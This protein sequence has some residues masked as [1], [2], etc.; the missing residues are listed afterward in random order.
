[1]VPNRF[2]ERSRNS[3]IALVLTLV[4]LPSIAH[5]LPGDLD[6]SGRVDGY[7]LILFSHAHGTS[8]GDPDWNP[9]ADLDG[10]GTV[11]QTDLD[12]LSVHFGNTGLTFGLWVGDQWSGTDRVAKLSST[13]N[14]LT[15]V[16]NFY[17]PGS[18]SSNLVDGSVWVADSYYDQVTKLDNVDGTTL[19]TVAGMVPYS[20]SVN[21]SDGSVWVADFVNNRVIKLLSDITDGYTIG[22]DT[23]SHLVINGFNHPR[24]VSVNP[25]TGV[26]WIADTS[27]NRI[28]R[29]SPDV[30][31]GYDITVDI[32]KH[33][34]KDGFS[35]PYVVSVNVADG[36]VWVADYAN[37]QV[38]KLSATGTTELARMDGFN[39]PIALD[40]NPIDG[41]VWIA[42][43]LN[44][45]VTRLAAD[46]SL[47]FRVDG[48]Y[49]PS[50]VAVDPLDGSAWIADRYNHQVVKLSA[51]GTELLRVGGFS[52]PKALSLTL[53]EISDSKYPTAATS[54]SAN[55]VEVGE[56]IIFTGTGTDPD[57]SIVLYEWD[58][59]GDGI[60]EYSSTTSGTTT[61]A[62]YSAE[63]L[64][65][66][67]FRVTDNDWLTAT[68]YTQI[69][70][71]GVLQV[72][73]GA[74]VISGAAPLTV[75]FSG[76]FVDPL[77][78]FVD[79]Y[80][81]DFDGNHIFDYYSETS[82]ATSFTYDEAGT[83]TATLKVT[84]GPHTAFDS[85][86][87]AVTSSSPT[88]SASLSPTIGPYPL[89]VHFVGSGS[90]LDGTIVLYEWDFEGDGLYDWFSVSET[91]TA[92]IYTT[93]GAYTPQLRVTD[94]D[95]QTA[96]VDLSVEVGA[97]PPLAVAN[98]DVLE[99]HVP[100]TVNVNANGS[101]DPDGTIVLYEWNFGDDL[102]LFSDNMENGTSQWSAASPWAQIADDFH[103]AATAWTDSPGGNYTNNRNVSLTSTTIDLSGVSSAT[104]S[105]WHH[106][107]TEFSKDYGHVEISTD[108]GT[109]WTE[110]AAYSGT[111]SA[112][113]EVQ[114]DLSAYLP[115]SNVRIRFR[116]SSDESYVYDGWYLDDVML[117][118]DPVNWIESLD[119]TLS[120]SY[121]EAGTS[122]ATLRV[123]DNDGNSAIDTVEI[124]VIPSH[125]P[126]VTASAT[127]LSG[128][129]PLTVNF[130][131]TGID[132]DGSISEY[133]WNFGEEY[134]WVADYSNNQIV[135]LAADG[136]ELVRVSGFSFP[137]SVSV[138]PTDGSVWV[139][140]T[141]H[142]QVVKLTADGTELLRVSGFSSPR[143]V[144][145]NPT[146][147]S[148]WVANTSQ[149]QIV[150]L[151]ADGTELVRASGFSSP[152]SV[153]TNP[154]DGSVWVADYSNHQV[155]KLS[156]DGTELVRASDFYYPSTV[157]INP[158]DGSVWVADYYNNQVVKLA[159]AGTE[160]VRAGGF[161]R[162]ISVSVN[163]ADGSVW[164]AD[165]NNNE[166]VKLAADGTELVRVSG[167]YRPRS[168]SVNPTDDMVWVADGA[169][170]GII[171]LTG[172]T[173]GGYDL[174]VVFTTPDVISDEAALLFGNA[175]SGTGQFNDGVILDGSGD[176]V[177]IP[178]NTAPDISSNFTIEAWIK[179]SYVYGRV[180]FMRGNDT[181]GDE[182]YLG[183]QNHTN[184]Q[185]VLDGGSPFYFSGSTNFSEDD[186]HHVALVYDAGEVTCYVDGAAYGTPVA[187][188]ATFD[189]DGSHALIGADFNAFNS[190]VGR[191]FNGQIDEVRLWNVARTVNEITD[192][193][194]TE[195][196]GSETGLIGYWTFN[197]VRENS[198]HETI[199]GFNN[200]YAVAVADTG[201][202]N[203]YS[204]SE[205]GDTSHLYSVPGIY[206]AIFTVTDND[207][208]TDHKSVDINVGGIPLVTI[209]ADK[210]EGPAPLE[211]FFSAIAADSDGHIVNYEWDFD[212]DGTYDYASTASGNARYVYASGGSY[213]ATVRVTDDDGY[214]DTDSVTITVTQASPEAIAHAAPEEGNA[215]LT[216]NFR[217]SGLDP[218]GT[219]T[220]HEWDFESDGTYDFS[221]AT[222]G[223]TTYTYSSPGT[224]TA[225]LR[226]TDN[227]GLTDTDAVTITV[228]VTGTPSALLYVTPS[229]GVNP[230]D[231]SFFIHG[232][233]PD[234]TITLYEM[235]VDGD[236]TYDSS[237]A[238]PA[239]VFGD[240]MEKSEISWTAD[241]PWAR[242]S[243]ETYSGSYAWTDSPGGDYVDSAN[244]SLTSTTIDLSAA[245]APKLIFRQ[246]YDLKYADYGRV[247][248]SGNDGS[249]WSQLG[250]VHNGILNEWTRQEYD[251]SSYA[252]NATVKIR[253]RFTS[254]ASDVA[255]GWYVDDVW[256]G[257]SLSHTYS[258][259]GDYTAVLRVTDNEGKQANVSQE[260]TVFAN[261]N[262][263]FIWVADYNNNQV[264]KL[265]DY[266]DILA[267]ISGFSYPRSVD[268]DLSDGSV[269]VA[270]YNNNRM[271]KLSGDIA[272]GY[273]LGTNSGSHLIVSGFN[274]PWSV[275]VDHSDGS[276]WIADYSNNQ[277]VKLASDGTELVRTSGFYYPQ[278]VSVNPTDGT[279]W[280]ADT[281]H[282]EVVKL[283]SDGTELVRVSG[284]SSPRSISVNP[285]DGTVWVANY[286]NHQVVKLAADGS[287]LWRLGG[288][289][290]PINVTA[291][292]S[293]GVVWV[294]DYSND[295]MVALSP[296]PVEIARIGGFDNPY[297]IDVN[298]LD[299]SVW[300]A[301][302]THNQVVKLASDGTELQ[303]ISGFY[304]PISIAVDTATRNL[305]NPPIATANAIPTSGM[306]FDFSGSATDDGTIVRYEWDVEGDGIYEYSSS[307]SGDTT[308]T[309]T[310]PGTY[311]P[312]FRVTDNDGMIG[313]DAS[314]TVTVGLLGVAPNASPSTGAAPLTVTLNGVVIAAEHH[315]TAFEWDFDGDGVFDFSSS[316]NPKTT[317]TYAASGIY[318]AILRVT[319]DLGHQAYGSTTVTV[320]KSPPS[321]SNSA[322][323]TS[324]DPPLTVTLNGSGSDPDG[325]IVLYE[326][327]YNEDGVYDWFSETTAK[328]YFRYAIPGS[329][330]VTIRV[331]DNDG[332][333]ATASR[334][335]TVNETPPIANAAADVTE[336][337]APLS[338]NFSGSG[339]DADGT[340]VLYE[341]DF[342]GDG[343]DDYSS[344]TNGDTSFTYNSTGLYTATLRVTDDDALTDTAKVSI[345]VKASGNP[346]AAANADPTSGAIPLTVDFDALGS[347]DPDGNLALYEWTFG[348]RNLIWVADYSNNQVVK[349][350]SDGTE[351]VRASGF[352]RPI[353]VSIYS[354]DGNVWV[355]D[356]YNN[357]VA[358][359]DENGTEQV[360]ASGFAYPRSVSVDSTDGSVWVADTNNH[361]VVRLA[362][363]GTELVRA[364]GFASPYDVSANLT[365]GSVWVADYGHHQVV[366]LVADGSELVR[367][368]GFAYPRS[369]TID[370][371]N[372][373]I[374]VADTNNHRI[375]KLASEIPEGYHT[376]V[377]LVTPDTISGE[378]ALLFG[379]AASGTGQFNSGMSLDGN[380]DYALIPANVTPD[381]S[382]TFT[383]EAWIK[384]TSI[385][386]S[387]IFMR[388][389]ETGGDELYLRL[390][391]TTTIQVILDEGSAINFNGSTTFTD[392][393][394]HHVALVY[395]AAEVTCYVDGAAYGTPA[396]V[397][398][399]LDFGG[400]HAL[401]GADFNAFNASPGRYFNGQI[402][403][404]RLWNVVRSETDIA[405]FKDI[406]LSGSEAG[407]VG[408]WTFNTIQETP[409]H[410]IKTGFNSPQCITINPLD[411]GAW[412]CD[413]N[414]NQ[415]VRV[416]ADARREIAR[417]DGFYQ[418]IDVSVNPLDGTVWVA[419][420][421]NN[422]MVHLASD[423][424]EIRRLSGFSS[425]KSVAVSPS[426]GYAYHSTADGVTTHTYT[427][428]GEYL[429]TLKVTDNEDNW[430]MDSVLITTGML[431]SLPI[432][433]PTSGPAPL[434]VR[435]SSNGSSSN[436]TIA[437]FNWDF[438][439][440]GSTD[441][442][443]PISD[444]YSYTYQT[445][446]SYTATQTVI[447]NRGLSDSASI[448]ITVL[449]AGVPTVEINTDL[450]EG[451]APLTVNF[452]GLGRDDD[453]FITQYEWDFDGD[454]VFDYVS[455]TSGTTS[456][457]YTEIGT[458][459]AMLRITDNENNSGSAS[460][461]IQIKEAG[462]P[463]ALAEA[464]PTIGVASLDVSFSGNGTDD[465]TIVL[466]E[467]DFD[468]DG[469]YDFSSPTTASTIHSYSNPGDFNAVLRVTDD[470]GL[471]DTAE[472]QI[473][474]EP[475]IIAT[476]SADLLD[477]TAGQT[478]SINSVLTTEAIVT[479]LI[480]NRTGN[481][482][483]TLVN[484]VPRSAG[485]YSDLWDGRD[486][487][488]QI[489]ADGAY[490]YVIEYTINGMTYIYDLTNDVDPNRYVPTL[491]YPA[492]FDPFNADM[493]FFR[494][495]LSTKSEVTIYV[496]NLSFS[497]G[498]ANYKI[499]TLLLRKPQAAG[500]YVFVWD[501][502]DDTGSLVSSTNVGY[503][504]TVTGWRLPE[505]A[506]IV[507]AEPIVSDLYATP[508]YLN[509]A[510]GPYGEEYQALLSY[511][512]S[513]TS[514]VTLS[515]YDAETYYLVR[516]ITMNNVPAG[517]GNSIVWDGKTDDGH[518]VAPGIYRLTVIASA[519]GYN[520]IPANAVMVIFY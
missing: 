376:S 316:L 441:W 252:G 313:H 320:E 398:T 293:T 15:R 195:L 132:P 208:Y 421:S 520:S 473:A 437:S 69:V 333:T 68:D 123:T 239:T 180:L 496:L 249:S 486:G 257:D 179:S 135:R 50:S 472:V 160:L 375:I 41:S 519:N 258:A 295:Q 373:T 253:F 395:D 343:M 29:L 254:N 426:S 499:K 412:V 298:E 148:V 166:V 237:S 433:Y 30:P 487:G 279:V 347:S 339:N 61:S 85:I 59:D 262:S 337:V 206:H 505:N 467:W 260:I 98:T 304:R 273:D 410:T 277:V 114:L 210:S 71:V 137:Q 45:Q 256:V 371:T 508:T 406:E 101:T 482:L 318:T 297:G 8:L 131:G 232:I 118:T 191:Y 312:V 87:I 308:H 165:Y 458:Y 164:V 276:V 155:V 414:N 235:D 127:P 331:T 46:G 360:R 152:Q 332:L 514:D 280:V 286:N 440:N 463:T 396:P 446:G 173:P 469:T 291:N 129:A 183:F 470:T 283:A 199:P 234:G 5:A 161:N 489:V 62:A 128:T 425:P 95:G 322:S 513:R 365:D 455:S 94:N 431:E 67:V 84:D 301:D 9:D 44:Q 144:S 212:G 383:L 359:L 106:Y 202:G 65:T 275:S 220:L 207:G 374:W 40:T 422:Q 99:G 124:T 328:T 184:I 381:I 111:L 125:L 203:T 442:T 264:M 479:V 380:G 93:P 278:A 81:W 126:L 456:H 121:T 259:H 225:I 282:S 241:A 344:S 25:I 47:I 141:S 358:K 384:P 408:Y 226:V 416:S 471:T 138:N 490:F 122:T 64:Y 192:N 361:Q 117:S 142:Q 219:I 323:P 305:N 488:G 182:L 448:P 306:S 303:R 13:G 352:N 271:V 153:S 224:Y 133:Q 402:D 415:M 26:V 38:V 209:V 284:F 454:G 341:W 509:P 436:A 187:V 245:T 495:T 342:D 149:H 269:W 97:M 447:D 143:S 78:G 89:T 2:P 102:A 355:A 189:F 27:N 178:A 171:K 382:S 310:S 351:L 197:E 302:Y 389:N 338:V 449:P 478:V 299:G 159:A 233:D 307:T 378:N 238:S 100:L 294:S 503:M 236:G 390:N 345:A 319:D 51:N 170:R 443:T 393:A 43:Y 243:S 494:Y 205:N 379:N 113:T 223:E 21:S 115:N 72:T 363:D 49:R 35:Q 285:T 177:L 215:P 75:N 246:R 146:D 403:E 194:D 417:V 82:A 228:Y 36:T 14:L 1:M 466:Y 244:V 198:Y 169:N 248:V 336:G 413:T 411:D 517:A 174:S 493:N 32:G 300:V 501:G 510:S 227:D 461:L 193:K 196:L 139:A 77:D 57:G 476:L 485:Y 405:T 346:T 116:F 315:I 140:D 247:E 424:T 404:V 185:V 92:Y 324:G 263:S 289:L 34:V 109:T 450:I 73:A 221:S 261:E 429:A 16:G 37:K 317:H 268:V 158:T 491:T 168:V 28:V 10:T 434:D 427:H 105:F 17:T 12:I 250:Y 428:V 502:T 190:S 91:D 107:N 154:T 334:T 507:N 497:S 156:P 217:G 18:L 474:V 33:V 475:G 134:V 151:G 483:R 457:T 163:P 150:K 330:T 362:A 477:P 309:Y 394:W 167:F 272:D 484:S 200:P 367:L 176:Y 397:S 387:T 288:F 430:D 175:T 400:S 335:I 53:D 492:A 23:G 348:D 314:L 201:A 515:I 108:G 11:D 370:S 368:S 216:V 231:V 452:M 130:S 162:P 56:T 388:G 325:A 145:V 462:A 439:G 52:Y 480:E 512:L 172:E 506:M 42:D 445:P 274:R 292:S 356:Y 419:D 213:P 74:D 392:G 327:D 22:T 296:A 110:L 460:V 364:S 290:N 31:D 435:F 444:N 7:D 104:L 354:T 103:S 357:Q 311:Y 181:G 432:A 498:S 516:S 96:T 511:T 230:L 240:D 321:A 465:G 6:S 20:V 211:I 112:W 329:Y 39:Q 500:S 66:P 214:T 350:A 459:T 186:W 369:L 418:P 88:A 340:I 136:T 54:L 60:F 147:G 218:D 58:I 451:F 270:D 24:S 76:S 63:G 385:Y 119:G 409:Y 366:K 86:T 504:I 326:W 453:G 242:V 464:S 266:G 438:D 70:R 80:Q 255:D 468:G 386:Y 407:L 83:Y 287:E 281:S 204:S 120:Y 19:L 401:I 423:G 229:E 157:S 372:D 377:E 79:N 349:L 518:Y 481:L 188:S 251:L 353:S 48:F 3:L 222:A 90:D 265:S 391:N 420:Q 4:F 399:T 55:N 267:T